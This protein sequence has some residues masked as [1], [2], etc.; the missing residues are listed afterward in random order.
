MTWS[1]WM[2]IDG[3]MRRWSA[4][5]LATPFFVLAVPT[6]VYLLTLATL[7]YRRLEQA[8]VHT[9][10]VI[11]KVAETGGRHNRNAVTSTF[12]AEGKTVTSKAYYAVAGSKHLQPGMRLGVV[13][14]RGRPENNAPTLAYAQNDIWQMK[15]FLALAVVLSTVL[16]FAFRKD[17]AALFQKVRAALGGS[18]AP[19]AAGAAGSIKPA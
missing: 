13:Y 12:Q 17:Y 1:K 6:L 14:E 16:L 2:Q 3:K 8:Q 5:F 18:A 7:D 10:A 19:Q 15:M 9:V 11:Q 4:M